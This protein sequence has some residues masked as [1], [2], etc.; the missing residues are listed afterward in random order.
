[1]SY[2]SMETVNSLKKILVKL[3]ENAQEE[4]L[5]Y[6]KILDVLD[7]LSEVKV[8]YKVLKETKVGFLLKKLRNSNPPPE[9]SKKL[10]QIISHWKAIVEVEKK[11]HLTEKKEEETLQKKSSDTTALQVR[12]AT[13]DTQTKKKLKAD[14]IPKQ[15]TGSAQRDLFIK[16]LVA[17][18][19]GEKQGSQTDF[20]SVA[21]EVE[22]ALFQRYNSAG[23]SYKNAAIARRACLSENSQLRQLLLSGALSPCEFA[24]MSPEEMETNDLKAAKKVAKEK[25]LHSCKQSTKTLQTTREFTCGKC[26]NDHCQ[27]FEMQTRSADEP[28]TMFVFC[29]T[30]GCNNK[31]KN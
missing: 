9:I 29:M 12:A 19:N 7:R 8:D 22:K 21:V 4:P 13:E 27:F 2:N 28:M 30:P 16:Q 23:I 15:K 1:M 11:K 24:K 3:T 25:L 31:W 14:T 17:I 26:K 5:A 6:P 18:F 20:V 10:K